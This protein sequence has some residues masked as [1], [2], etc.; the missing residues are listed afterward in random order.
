[1]KKPKT[2][3]PSMPVRVT[4]RFDYGKDGY[5]EYKSVIPYG[6]STIIFEDL[7]NWEERYLATPSTIAKYNEAKSKLKPLLRKG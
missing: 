1:M 3:E 6:V 7:L 4:I 2:N 5:T